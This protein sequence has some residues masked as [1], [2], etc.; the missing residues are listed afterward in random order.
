MLSLLVPLVLSLTPM[1]EIVPT[2]VELDAFSAT[3][4]GAIGRLRGIPRPPVVGI[5]GASPV[6]SAVDWQAGC[7]IAKAVVLIGPQV[8]PVEDSTGDG[9]VTTYRGLY[10]S[11]EVYPEPDV[12]V[13]MNGSTCGRNSRCQWPSC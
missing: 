4:V 9:C 6:E 11:E 1:T 7:L 2:E 3:V 5:L 12:F 13:L 10:N 8:E